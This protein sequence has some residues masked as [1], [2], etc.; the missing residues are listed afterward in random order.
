MLRPDGTFMPHHLCPM[1]EVLSGA[2]PEARDMEVQIERPDGSRVTV[3]DNIRALK[4]EYGV[5]T[6]AINCFVDI[7]QRQR[8]QEEIRR[9]AERFRFLA[10]AMPQKIFTTTATGAVDYVNQQWLDCGGLPSSRSGIGVGCDLFIPMTRRRACG[11]GNTRSRLGNLSK[12]CI[13]SGAPMESTIG[14]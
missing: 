9:A 8:V 3:I 10:E 12:W 11:A 2:I 14:T 4:N 5:I 7:T 1:A 6:G 13:A